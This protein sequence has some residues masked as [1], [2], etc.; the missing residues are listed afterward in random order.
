MAST[1][2]GPRRDAPVEVFT[3][4]ACLGNPG[5]GG[6]AAV[7]RRGDAEK[8]LT[9][10]ERETTNNRMELTAA[11]RALEAL[12]R[13]VAVRLHNRL[14][15]CARRDRQVARALEDQRL[16]HRLARPGAQP[17]PVAGAGQRPRPPQG[18]V[19]MGARPRR[20]TPKTNAPTAWPAP[21]P[22]PPPPGSRRYSAARI[23]S[24]AETS[25]P[26]PSS[27]ART[28]TTPS[29]TTIA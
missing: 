3:D 11:I 29:S 25:R 1:D 24:A 6:W 9:G 14:A 13:P 10:G 27:T 21:P 4:G 7:L 15:L 22:A 2:R 26:G 18:R 5:P 20:P 8:E 16:A 12:K 17:R 23:F 19:D 28:L